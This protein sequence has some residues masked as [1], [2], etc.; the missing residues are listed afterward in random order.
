MSNYK[1]ILRAEGLAS[2][3]RTLVHYPS[4]SKVE[5][6]SCDLAEHILPI[7]EAVYPNVTC[8]RNILN[9][10]KKYLENEDRCHSD[11]DNL[12]F[13]L[14]KYCR[15]ESGEG[16]PNEAANYAA[17]AIGEAAAVVFNN[18]IT[19]AICVADYAV[20]AA[21]NEIAEKKWQEELFIKTF[22]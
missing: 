22:C 12:D 16:Y 4:K 3:I 7:F 17:E 21:N 19:T 8:H 5:M 20:N 18:P 6:F 1:D 11:Y 15:S 13:E 9:T 2:A 14:E 10:A